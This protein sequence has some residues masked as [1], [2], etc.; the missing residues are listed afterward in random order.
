MRNVKS[1]LSMLH[2]Q[3]V[4]WFYSPRTWFSL[5]VMLALAY[6]NAKSF[7]HMLNTTPLYAHL[8]ECLFYYLDRGIGNSLMTSF[9][10]L[11]M[12]SEIPRMASWQNSM[13]I[14]GRKG[15]WL[16]A[17]IAYGFLISLC[18]MLALLLFSAL[19]TLPH[20]TAGS[21]WSDVER[22]MA[23]A[24]AMVDLQLTPSFIHAVSPAKAC[25]YAGAVLLL[26]WFTMAMVILLCTLHGKPTL[27]IVVFASLLALH[28]TIM[29]E[30]LPAQLNWMPAHFAT[31]HAI[32]D[33][34]PGR[35]LQ[36]TRA[37]LGAYLGINAVLIVGMRHRVKTMDLFFIERDENV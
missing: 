23:N 21:G 15:E 26:F 19:I 16:A 32:A 37:V 18:T 1:F 20:L 24:D 7:I 13:L 4:D 34:F 22:I 11:V 9:Q 25:L 5:A 2:G 12:M 3:L 17:Q 6:M 8:G 10:F 35:E 36:A 27:G 33:K 29:W 14:R 28:I 30:A 31:T